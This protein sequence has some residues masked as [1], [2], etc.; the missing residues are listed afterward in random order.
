MES[1]GRGII[2]AESE[3]IL[4]WIHI[5]E[6]K[7][8]NNIP[9]ESFPLS[10]LKKIPLA[11][12]VVQSYIKNPLLVDGFKFDLRL[13]VVVTSCDPLR[14]YLFKEGLVRICTEKFEIPNSGN[15]Q[16]PFIH[17]TNYTVNKNNEKFET[18]ISTYDSDGSTGNKRTLKWF[19]EWIELQKG[20][21]AKEKL[22]DDIVELV[23][24]TLIGL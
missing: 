18:T 20:F 19:L 16:N 6:E 5:S 10:S 9:N 12:A 24:L 2:L 13:Y 3:I 1:E 21:N 14:V 8:Q 17:L 23:A 4:N 22:L 15:L 7:L 11:S